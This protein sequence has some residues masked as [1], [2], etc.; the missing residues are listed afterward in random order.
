M[1]IPKLSMVRADGTWVV[2]AGG[3]VIGESRRAVE[4]VERDDIPG[5]VY[6]PREDLGMA[7]LE[8]SGG[9]T[10]SRTFGEAR[11]FNLVTASGVI[12]EVAWSYE[13]PGPGAERIAGLIAF[14]ATRVAVEEI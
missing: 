3:A 9:V 7:F 12:P 1:P 11:L 4:V 5:V 2:R 13:T 8:G 14:D 6:F 10:A